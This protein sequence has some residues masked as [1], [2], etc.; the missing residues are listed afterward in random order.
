MTIVPKGVNVDEIRNPNGLLYQ[1]PTH[2]TEAS[3][4]YDQSEIVKDVK[5]LRQR[6]VSQV[7][8][9]EDRSKIKAFPGMLQIRDM[10]EK[11]L[12]GLFKIIT[13]YHTNILKIRISFGNSFPDLKEI[14][15]TKVG[16]VSSRHPRYGEE[17]AKEIAALFSDPRLNVVDMLY[18]VTNAKPGQFLAEAKAWSSAEKFNKDFFS[19]VVEIEYQSN[20]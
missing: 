9:Y 14:Y 12:Q 16:N 13:K 15:D 20:M 18:Y 19:P 3:R 8:T 10:T 17:I 7:F 2:I 6:L 4:A 1:N 11:E 5:D